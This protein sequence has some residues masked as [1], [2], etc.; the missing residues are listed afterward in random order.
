MRICHSGPCSKASIRDLRN[1]T[2][3]EV[4]KY[5]R[6][7]MT[8]GF[9]LGGGGKEGGGRFKTITGILGGKINSSTLESVSSRQGSFV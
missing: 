4:F 5:I 2:A 6:I 3:E 9:F 1:S 7:Y 8:Y